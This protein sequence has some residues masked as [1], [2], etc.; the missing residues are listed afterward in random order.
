MN[1]RTLLCVIMVAL[2]PLSGFATNGVW[3]SNADDNWTTASRWVN[4]Q[5]AGGI[6]GVADFSQVDISPS[7]FVTLN[8]DRTI[9][10][11]I[12]GDFM[13]PDRERTFRRPGTLTLEV[14]SGI[15]VIN[16]VN[17]SMTNTAVIAGTQGFEKQGNGILLLAA[18]NI[19]TG[20]VVLQ[21]GQVTLDF[22][23]TLS[24]VDNIIDA[25]STLT[26]DGA[27]LRLQGAN[28]IANS[29]TFNGLELRDGNNVISLTNGSGGTVTLNLGAITRNTGF[30]DFCPPA[31]GKGGII[32]VTP[33]MDGIL[34]CYATIYTNDWAANNGANTIVVYTA[35]ASN[36]FLPGFNT[37]VTTNCTMTNA[38]VNSLRFNNN[39]GFTL[40]LNGTNTISAGGIMFTT[41]SAM[42]SRIYS[43]GW[44]TSGTN[45]LIIIDNHKFDRRSTATYNTNI[46]AVVTDRG[47]TSVAVRVASYTSVFGTQNGSLTTLART[48]N[49][50]SG[51]TYLYGGGL[52]VYGDGSFGKVPATPQTNIIAASGF[53]W[54][55]PRYAMTTDVNRIISIS[56]NAFLV[57]DGGSYALTINGEI[58]GSG[59]LL[60]PPYVTGQPVILNGSNTMT[61]TIEANN[62]ALRMTNTFSLPPTANLRLAGDDWGWDQ[63]IVEMNGTF[64]RDLGFGPNQ[65]A[66]LSTIYGTAERSGGFAAVGGPLTV[67]IGGQGSNLVWGQN[68]FNVSA[69]FNFGSYYSTHPVTW[70]NPIY[71]N[72]TGDRRINVRGTA[73][74]QGALLGIDCMLIKSAPGTL[75]LAATNTYEMTRI[76]QGTIMA[77]C[78][79]NLGTAPLTPTNNILVS[80]YGVL[81]AGA[82]LVVGNT[83][84]IWIY[85]TFGILDSSNYVMTVL[86]AVH[87]LGGLGKAG[88]GQVVLSSE[89]TYAGPTM[90]S[91]GTLVVNGSLYV[92]SVVAATNTGFLGGTGVVNGPVIVFSGS[93]LMPG[94]TNSGGTLTL[95][96]KLTMDSGSIYGWRYDSNSGLVAVSNQIT[97]T[98]GGTYTLRLYNPNGLAEPVN[99]QFTIMT[100]PDSVT[101]PDTNI[102]WIIEKPA[103]GGAEGWAVPQI[104]MDTVLN[105]ILIT[106]P[107]AGFP[108]VDNGAGASS[109][110]TNTAVLNGNYTST[111]ATASAW[112]Y[113]GTSD[114]GTNKANWQW[115]C[116]NGLTSYGAFSN[117]VSDLYYGFRYYYRCYASNAVGECWNP[118]SSSFVTLPPGNYADGLRGSLFLNDYQ[119]DFPLRLDN[120]AYNISATRVFTGY[121]SGTI[122]AMAEAPQWNVIATGEISAFRM[123]VG[124]PSSE[125]FISAICGQFIPRFTGVHNFRWDCDDWGMMYLD[126]NG[127]GTFEYSEGSVAGLPAWY[128]NLI[129]TLTAGQPYNFIF[130][131][132]ENAGGE[133]QNFFITEPGQAEARVNVAL[134]A[135]MWR[136]CLGGAGI[137]ND[138][139]SDVGTTSAV[140]N[141]VLSSS[142]AVSEVWAYWGPVDC[143]NFASVWANSAYM[144]SFTNVATNLSYLATG[145]MPDTPYYVRFSAT[146]VLSTTWSDVRSFRTVYQPSV[147][148]GLASPCRTRITFSG[149]NKGETLT[150]FPVLV[151]LSE[152]MTNFLYSQFA[153]GSG[154]D[155]RFTDEAQTNELCYE[156]EQWNPGCF[157]GLPSGVALWLKAD[158]GVLTNTSGNVTNW[159]DQSGWGRDANNYLGDPAV[160]TNKLGGKPVVNFD[161]NDAVYTSFNF[162]YLQQY[163]VFSV[164]RYT[165]PDTYGR[166]IACASGRNWIFGFYSNGDERW[167]FDGWIYNAGTANTNWHLHAG[168]MNNDSDPKANLWKDGNQLGFNL[169]GSSDNYFKPGRVELGGYNAPGQNEM[170]KS[171]VAEVIIFDHVLT[172]NEL[173][174]VGGYL[175]QKYG[176]TSPY[177]ATTG[178]SYVWVKVPEFTNNCTIW[179]YWGNTN[180]A[181]APAYTTNGSVWSEG[182]LGVWH[183][184][185]TNLLDSSSNHYNATLWNSDVVSTGLFGMAQNFYSITNSYVGLGTIRIASDISV[186]AWA[187]STNFNQNGVILGKNPVNSRWQLFF[188]GSSLK[189]RASGGDVTVSVPSSN[190]WHYL[191]AVQS[192][193]D[194]SLYTNG[195]LGSSGTI[196]AIADGSGSVDIGRYN[197]GYYFNGMIDEIRLSSVVRSSNWLWACWMNLA[198]NNMFSAC[199]PA[200]G[201]QNLAATN[202]TSTSAVLNATLYTTGLVTDV[203]A[204]W[205][206]SDGGTNPAAWASSNLVGSFTNIL[207]TNISCTVTSLLSGVDYYFTFRAVS[208]EASPW[209]SSSES[210]R[211]L[212]GLSGFPYKMKITFSGYDRA[213]TLT[214]FPALVTFNEGLPSFLYSQFQA[215][216]TDLRFVDEGE[217]RELNYE[218]D[219]WNTNG[220]SYVWVQVPELANGSSIWAY[221]GN[222]G[223]T[224]APAYTANG[225]TWSSNY[226]RGVWHMKEP[227]AV[228]STWLKNN[229]TGV[230]NTNTDGRIGGAQGFDNSYIQIANENNF[231]INDKLT[232][233]A[234]VRVDGDWRTGWQAFMSKDGEGEGWQIRR[235]S[236]NDTLSF[237]M[238]GTTANDDCANGISTA[239][240]DGQWHY[241]FGVYDYTQRCLYVDGVVD[242]N[243]TDTG[244]LALDNEPVRIGA[245]NSAGNRHRGPIDEV[246]IENAARSSNWMWACWLNQASNSFFNT[247]SAAN[248]IRNLSASDITSTSAVMNA[249]LYASNATFDVSVYWGTN[250]CGTNI[251]L[252]ANTNYVG[253]WTN[254]D[255]TNISCLVT[256]LVSD[257]LY[258]YRF[259]A[260]NAANSYQAPD[261]LDFRTL[262]SSESLAAYPYR[263]PITFSGYTALETLTNFPALVVLNEG[264][265]G[266]FYNQLRSTGT[267]L[268]FTD[269]ATNELSYEIEQWNPGGNSYVWV[270]VPEFTNNCLIWAYWGNAD[271]AVPEYLTNGAVW[272]TNFKGVWHLHANAQDSTANR[273]DG[274]VYGGGNSAPTDGIIGNSWNFDG[275]DNAVRVSRMIQ[276]DF[277]IACW[278]KAGASSPIGPQWTNGWG[279]VDANVSGVQNDFGLA[280]NTN[281]ASFGTGNPD[282]TISAGPQIND[283]QWHYV[284][285]TRVR[286]TGVKNLYVD[287]MYCGTQTSTTNRLTTPGVIAFGQM[288]MWL[289]YYN[290]RIDEVEIS[291]VERSA[292]W[293]WASYM[294][295]ASNSVFSSEGF[296]EGGT[297]PYIN[298]H[299]GASDVMM[300]SASLNGYLVSTGGA[301]T[302]VSVYWGTTDG[303]TNKGSWVSRE[304]FIVTGTDLLTTNV[305]GLVSGAKYYYRFYAS[306]SFGDCWAPSSASFSP[307]RYRMKVQFGGYDKPETL[308]N[309][310]AL[311]M[312]ADGSNGF[313]Y[314][315]CTTTNGIELRFANSNETQILNHE[316][317]KWDTNGSSYVWVQVPE[318][319]DTNTCVWAYWGGSDTNVPV[320]LTNGAAWSQD[321]LAV[322]HFNATNT[323]SKYPDSTAYRFDGINMGCESIQGQIAGATDIKIAPKYIDIAGIGCPST[324]YTFHYWLKTT[325]L[326]GDARMVD[327]ANG[328]LIT[329][330]TGGAVNYYDASNN[331]RS[332]AG[333]GVNNGQWR[334]VVFVFKGDSPASGSMYIDGV[335]VGS[336]ITY[337]PAKLGGYARI[338]CDAWTP[339]GA[340]FDG[341][342]DEFQIATVTRSSNWIWACYMNQGWN[343]L[344]NTA[345]P[346]ES[347]SLPVIDNS[348]STNSVTMSSAYI[349]GY[350]S[351]TG[352]ASTSVSVYWG[353]TDGGTNIGAWG[354]VINFGLSSAGPLSTN[355]TGLSYGTTYYYRYYAT[356]SFGE[357]WA[358][359]STAFSPHKYQMQIRFSGYN[360][361]ETLTNFPALVVFSEGTNGF[362]Y[363]QMSSPVGGDLRFMNSNETVALNYEIEQWDPN[364]DPNPSPTNISGLMLWL[365]ADAGIQTNESGYVTSWT[366]QSGSNVIASQGITN[367]QPLYVE[368]AI[369]GQPAVRF[370][371]ANDQMTWSAVPAQTIF[372][373][374]RVAVGA[375]VYAGLIG[376]NNND[377]GIR[378]E[379]STTWRHQGSWSYN[380]GDF[381]YQGGSAF[382]INGYGTTTIGED[383]W[384]IVT[385]VK[386]D[387]T[388]NIDSIGSYYGGR[389]FGGDYAEVIIYNRI[390]SFSEQNRVGWYLAQKYGLTT[391]YI[392]PAGQSYVWVQVPEF[393]ANGYIWAYWGGLDTNPPACTWNGSTWD[394]N[395]KGVWHMNQPNVKDST[396]NANNGAASSVYVVDVAGTIG[397][398]QV[399]NGGSY[400]NCGVGA[401][402]NLPTRLT[403]EAWH[404]PAAP[405]FTSQRAFVN[406]DSA[407]SFSTYTGGQLRFTTPGI[408]DHTSTGAALV[409]NTWYHFACTFEES[410]TAGCLFYKNGNQIAAIN[411][412]AMNG[413]NNIFQIG[414]SAAIGIIDEVRISD[415]IRSSNWMWACY[416]NQ[417]SNAAL[418]TPT[419]FISNEGATNVAAGS[420][421]LLGY[422]HEDDDIPT[423][424]W[425]YYGLTDGGSVVTN[426]QYTNYLGSLTEGL[427]LS[428]ADSLQADKTYYYRYYASNAVRFAWA[429]PS[430]QFFTGEV[431]IYA[432]DPSAS[433]IGPDTGMFTVY[434]LTSLTNEALTVNYVMDGTAVNGVDYQTL[435]GSVVIPAGE[436][437][438]TF[439]VTPIEDVHIEGNETVNA[440]L[441]FGS[442]AIGTPSNAVVTIHDAVSSEWPYRMKIMFP[443]FSTLDGEILTNFPVS[444]RFGTHIPAFSY[445]TFALPESG[446][447][448][449]FGNSSETKML[450][451]EIEKWD[452]SSNSYVWV[453]VPELVNTNTYIWA[454]WGHK[455]VTNAPAYTTNGSTW[456]EGFAGVWHMKESGLPYADSSSNRCNATSGTAPSQSLNGVIGNG[457]TFNGSTME[458]IVPYNAALNT[459]QFTVGCWAKVTG[460]AGAWRTPI[461]S[462]GS[463]TGYNLYAGMD[464]Q[465]QAWIGTGGTWD[466]M[467]GGAIVTGEWTYVNQTIDSGSNRQFYINGIMVSNKVAASF[468]VNPSSSL[469]IGSA[470]TWG[471]FNGDL[472]EVRVENVPRSSNWVWNCWMNQASNDMFNAY[473]NIRKFGKGT[474]IIV[475]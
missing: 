120:A 407:F 64:T 368:G 360:K 306:N 232:V 257:V 20:P 184:N 214:N 464:E 327:I 250:N 303:G 275:L 143:T 105:R 82:D 358:A 54:I 363:S 308:T 325:T 229:G 441:T 289:N 52:Y 409:T 10:T 266:F 186:E 374:N 169:T 197:S 447:D 459:T 366:D 90:I 297:V 135:G 226:Y 361:D 443:G 206:A 218:I 237:C 401:S 319:V 391:Y 170:S 125:Y 85:S 457:Q 115:V 84:N 258:Y 221:W 130:M 446:G 321:Y 7:R 13:W 136:Y 295:Q 92:D 364:Y 436:T 204:Y 384:H 397:G 88:S 189:W 246:R 123:F 158:V 173:N 191:A 56:T 379:N 190:N 165:G 304:D 203:V 129:V 231:D 94:G 239:V 335:L 359:S 35:Y 300:N 61:G 317:E 362:S 161:G 454:Y 25:G 256:G 108:A 101:D 102:T 425:M 245:N 228:D 89:N 24:P 26:M 201:I 328:R 159:L 387:S 121:K 219:T 217:T 240:K 37:M 70:I 318:L 247:C 103:G 100:W 182:Y 140:F 155:L 116:T 414:A 310:P 31:P 42:A 175:S 224:V 382:R 133:T 199:Q 33:N 4:N 268:R 77:Y 452:S 283:L 469:S 460:G 29:Q 110:L 188:E 15:P 176:L 458:V 340:H 333:S 273:Y 341:A 235:Y 91:N 236:G 403:V 76:E 376:L 233:S 329:R 222:P 154:A 261:T 99:Q 274:I 322:W 172:S 71:L 426:W 429:A 390:L 178:E 67:N 279:L 430:A 28:T 264:T 124:F 156:I 152:S 223:M 22:S 369:N 416:M 30:V 394:A 373:V 331:W 392:Q 166:V 378:R 332:N 383:A 293:I 349:D 470:N 1:R 249:T 439:T 291:D 78:D 386:G 18:A 444:V 421:D 456:S 467:P 405:S 451:Y 346:V 198:S 234:W 309:F 406:K 106:F 352:G 32:T 95:K 117:A 179:A 227:N 367:N 126:L 431:V 389:E 104:T 288:Q 75:V 252:W 97:L 74:M 272:N 323:I 216:A 157:T 339:G 43:G 287:G 238:R 107:A 113:W 377:V 260:T 162:D 294:N 139:P 2:L 466:T 370:D 109:I 278:M 399:F 96:N 284:V 393:M 41:N 241:L 285:A 202:I 336:G 36:I 400:I 11:I 463:S 413:N 448:L 144:G 307:S 194:A 365:K 168:T 153:S 49:T 8:G 207:S 79:A 87:G 434:R 50:Y 192:G 128:G 185:R 114:G 254:V 404:K 440:I 286:S 269:E 59:V 212:A 171:E 149:Y 193:T 187:Y 267:D 312:F 334:H 163:T 449:R 57:L 455:S 58:T 255:S 385:A 160:V 34:G 111:G 412:S 65:V 343:G 177:T 415:V 270:K 330:V 145:L 326:S 138:V 472:D 314:S 137:S 276:D 127:N 299:N 131:T 410:T 122:L 23:G 411:S 380:V 243:F 66:W 180:A 16:V 181:V 296:V 253:S 262:F 17:R 148:A 200:V 146:N 468:A 395:Y 301:S 427:L 44:L 53:N 47:T 183:M 210:F 453:Q 420:A 437:N 424:V 98:S 357:S 471:W 461:M 356:N 355:V 83:R 134:Q 230:G 38:T 40:T 422:L 195:V 353:T 351:S 51:G 132:K 147:E 474:V 119:S 73:I 27:I 141:A 345:S 80:G 354:N 398:A 408:L 475:R 350:L 271:A 263:M 388:Y 60:G 5:I 316:I 305:T 313:S 311:V 371:G 320:C 292:N 372:V 348:G 277:T 68:Y 45:E 450:N 3:N 209:A 196:G 14:T 55:K 220:S 213:E 290:G 21:R 63:G 259:S 118:V 72:S 205:G 396:A 423:Y 151:V 167:H 208:A 6:D 344:F 324:N 435:G 438:A 86:G 69:F 347:T 93:G 62:N 215:G 225:A 211:T 445:S 48:N 282:Q 302:A 281:Q 9:G 473:G 375:K 462:R 46:D 19:F 432:T 248:G 442:Y 417:A 419:F 164:A 39:P 244:Y 338:G 12:V 465:W 112:I 342:L 242:S 174:Q 428:T 280:Y 315:Q 298:N 265:N 418:M 337:V 251:T 381:T 402:L 433:E 81:Q 150:N 142:N